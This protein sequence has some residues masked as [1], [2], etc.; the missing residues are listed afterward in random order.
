MLWP[1]G[2]QQK[3]DGGRQALTQ[4]VVDFETKMDTWK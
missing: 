1:H 3:A 2:V 4:T